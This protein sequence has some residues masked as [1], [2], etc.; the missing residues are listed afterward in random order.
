MG[1]FSIPTPSIRP[2]KGS[3]RVWLGI[4]ASM[5]LSCQA[6]GAP[7]ERTAEP[8]AAPTSAPVGRT[9]EP[10]STHTAST[11]TSPAAA[12]PVTLTDDEGTEV[13]LREEPEQVIGLSPANTE[14]LFALGVDEKVVGGTDFDDFPPE[15]AELPD[16][17]TFNGVLIEKVVEL[18]PD[19]V[20]AAGNAFTP[21]ADIERMR[22]LRIPVLVVYAE[23][24]EEVLADIRLIGAAVGAGAEA[25]R[26]AAGMTSRIDEIRAAAAARADRPR[27]FYQ[28]GSEPEIYG[29]APDSFIEDMIEL[30]G[31]EPI[32]TGDPNVFSIPL[33]R[34]VDQDPEVIVVGDAQYGVC[35]ET[36][37][38]R[39]GWQTMTAVRRG[40]VRAIDDTI[41]TRPGPRLA[42]GLA[43][44][45]TAI[46][47]DI[48]LSAPPPP[49]EACAAPPPSPAP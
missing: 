14:T 1:P 12:F 18:E 46:H 40:D 7:P 5:L 39:R 24:V 8:T 34:L 4:V 29:P 32:T 28:I 47:P 38:E 20:I 15:A 35:P 27:V 36:V 23:S 10:A 16:V 21:A 17:A 33:E 19:L 9:I 30:A 48:E 26:I 11:S 43:A 22:D 6:T 25:N 45:A 2:W 13:T 37:M 42:E 44:L 3:H 31:G 41:V 49:V